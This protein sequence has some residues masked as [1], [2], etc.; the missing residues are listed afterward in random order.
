M[1]GPSMVLGDVDVTLLGKI[2]SFE[3][4]T[5]CFSFYAITN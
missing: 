5:V 4:G 1:Q 3:V 2:F